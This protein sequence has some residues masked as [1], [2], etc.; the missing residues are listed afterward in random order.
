M[1]IDLKSKAAKQEKTNSKRGKPDKGIDPKTKKRDLTL[2]EL[3]QAVGGG[4]NPDDPGD[5]CNPYDGAQH[6]EHQLRWKEAERAAP[7]K[8][9]RLGRG[10]RHRA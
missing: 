1:K 9:K 4:V 5:P 6:I 3:G 8:S 10:R 7:T 2:R